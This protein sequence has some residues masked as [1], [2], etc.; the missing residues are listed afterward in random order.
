LVILENNGH[1]LFEFSELTVFALIDAEKIKAKIFFE[2]FK[3]I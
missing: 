1:F 2:P 3:K